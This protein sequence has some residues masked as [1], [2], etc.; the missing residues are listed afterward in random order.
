MVRHQ[1]KWSNGKIQPT[2]HL[3]DNL[4]W[5]TAPTPLL[6]NHWCH[7]QQ[8]QPLTSQCCHCGWTSSTTIMKSVSTI[9][10]P[11]PHFPWVQRLQ[12]E[13]PPGW[14][15]R[16]GW[17]IWTAKCCPPP[18]LKLYELLDLVF[19]RIVLYLRKIACGFKKMACFKQVKLQGIEKTDSS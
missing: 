11:L 4:I 5:A 18:R 16:E 19:E 6:Q 8:S 9:P 17:S 1:K 2:S 7:Q 3:R 15:E 14:A 13:H 12:M 10:S